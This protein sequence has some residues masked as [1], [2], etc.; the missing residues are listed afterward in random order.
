MDVL[1]AIQARKSVRAFK[2][3]PVPVET[4]AKLLDIAQPQDHIA[5]QNS[6]GHC[7]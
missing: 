4:I 7:H 6:A 2:P 1:E 5:G 3:D